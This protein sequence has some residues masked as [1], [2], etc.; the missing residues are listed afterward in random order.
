M[1]FFPMKRPTTGVASYKMVVTYLG[2]VV[3]VDIQTRLI[4]G[5]TDS[6]SLDATRLS[7][8]LAS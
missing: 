6:Q 5:F 2:S 7:V 4:S 1:F 8:L 3:L